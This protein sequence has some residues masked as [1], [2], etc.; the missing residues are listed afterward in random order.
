DGGV[1]I[2]EA[3]GVKFYTASE[4]LTGEQL[5]KGFTEVVSMNLTSARKL[6]EGVR[7]RAL[8]D[9]NNPLMG[10]DGAAAVFGPQKGADEETVKLLEGRLAH[11][12][13]LVLKH[14]GKA[15][16]RIRHGGAAGGVAAGLYGTL[17]AELIN[18]G[19]Q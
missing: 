13:R 9:V 12:S 16:G 7:I 17:D 10:Q 6:L 3:L 1:G 18:G 4:E 14:C 19:E 8:C 2:L 5:L 11:W 15:V